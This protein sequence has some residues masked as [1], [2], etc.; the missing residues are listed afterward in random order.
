MVLI[1]E[2]RGEDGPE[3]GELGRDCVLPHSDD[4]FEAK[5]ASMAHLPSRLGDKLKEF[6]HNHLERCHWSEGRRLEL[7]LESGLG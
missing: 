4:I 1:G 5:E 3:C 2:A 6:G 7:G